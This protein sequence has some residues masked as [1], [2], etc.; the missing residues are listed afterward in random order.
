M[1]EMY[2]Q[3]SVRAW[4][5][6]VYVNTT[7]FHQVYSWLHQLLFKVQRGEAFIG[8]TTQHVCVCFTHFQ[9]RYFSY[10]DHGYEI[11]QLSSDELHVFMKE[12][13]HLAIKKFWR[14][15]L[16]CVW[17]ILSQS[18]TFLNV[19]V[20]SSQSCNSGHLT[21]TSKKAPGA[22]KIFVQVVQ[23]MVF[24]KMPVASACSS[25]WPGYF[26]LHLCD[27][28]GVI[29]H[30]A[31]SHICKGWLLLDRHGDLWCYGST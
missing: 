11:M 4:T 10:S 19:A 18:P 9:S 13:N 22:W 28:L 15:S 16:E 20:G 21:C 23:P 1:A 8:I 7:T 5:G 12:N 17:L 25:E 31:V 27:I 26:V 14:V 29:S 24:W 6:C 2:N 3:F 30:L